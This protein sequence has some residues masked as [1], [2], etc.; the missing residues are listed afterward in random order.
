M[1][2]VGKTTAARSI[3]RRYDLRLYSVDSFTY[4]H[5]ER[6]PKDARSLD[7]VWVNS[8][9]EGL[10]AWFDDAARSRFPLILGDRRTHPSCR[11]ACSCSQRFSVPRSPP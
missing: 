10:A 2:G 1:G 7:E 4:A 8:T 11:R 3:A 5:A 6:L 9:P